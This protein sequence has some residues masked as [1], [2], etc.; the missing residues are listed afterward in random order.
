MIEPKI[1]SGLRDYLPEDMIPRQKVLDT[2]RRVFECFGFLPLDTP[3][4]EQEEVLTGG[5]SNFK[6]SIF[7]TNV[8]NSPQEKLALRFDLTVPLARVVAQ[9]PDRIKKPFKRYA[10]G[11]VWRGEK[12]QA[13]RFREFIQF[14]ADTVGSSGMMADA[15]VIAIMYETMTALGIKN[16][17]TRVNNRKILNG[18]AEYAGFDSEKN[19]EV[20][21]AIDKMDRQGWE[22]V[23]KEL[24]ME[25]KFDQL[26]ERT[27]GSAL[28][29][30]Q[31]EAVRAFLDL[32]AGEELLD[33]VEVLMANSPIA[34]EG[35]EEL[36]QIR[37][38][39]RALG[40]PDDRWK[41]DLSVA[42]GL[43]YY[44]GPVFETVLTD[45]PSIGSVFSGGRYDNL[46]NRFSNVSVPATGASVGVDRLFAAMEQLGLVERRTSV[47]VMV[48]NFDASCR[49]KCQKIAT[50]LRRKGIK[51]EIYLG[52]AVTLK[53][54]LSHAVRQDVPVVII[55]G[56][57]EAEKEIC[58]V[59]NLRTREQIEVPEAGIVS[60]IDRILL[61]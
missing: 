1:T 61:R 3:A 2:I 27:G 6:M 53:E 11:P 37:S 42:R 10:V 41:I 15:E 45:L 46:V 24:A 8:P 49:A 35:T 55:L 13:G 48:L 9:Y 22:T 28:S 19:P 58:K 57:Y 47:D 12:P 21:R 52:A 20:L 43:G 4:I 50:I 5:D 51:T 34:L 59:K 7:R 30:S 60:I 14:D 26:G 32:P 16:F 18:L 44:T 40:V 38:H 33:E 25:E 29:L 31:I 36:R 17:L 23:K 56:S 54:Q 39:V